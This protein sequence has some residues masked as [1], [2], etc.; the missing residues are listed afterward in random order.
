M[1]R[2]LSTI[3]TEFTCT[4]F[5]ASHFALAASENKLTNEADEI[6]EALKVE[7]TLWH[8]IFRPLA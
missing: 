1:Y 7:K 4:R 8:H 6:A 2:D 3:D 5:L